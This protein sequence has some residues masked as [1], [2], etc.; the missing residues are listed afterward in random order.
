MILKLITFIFPWFIRRRLLNSWFGFKIDPKARIG[1]SW[2]FPDNLVMEEGS[3]IGHFNVAI[4]LSHI[5]MSKNSKIARANWITGY[6]LGTESK[7][8]QHQVERSPS[9]WIGEFSA[10]TK[11]HHFDCT[12]SI[13]V[14]DFSTIAGYS[15]QFLTHSIDVENNRQDSKPIYIG[16][17]TF[18]STNVVVLGGSILPS[19]SI[20]GAKALLNKSFSDEWFLYGG[21]PAKALKDIDKSSKYFSRSDGFVY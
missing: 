20:L 14:D 6:P 21:V 3:S 7:H 13:T 2:I 15:S 11:N 5:N 4:N 1:F 16:K 10:I 18:V 17:Y 8:F 12:N 9:L 19:Y